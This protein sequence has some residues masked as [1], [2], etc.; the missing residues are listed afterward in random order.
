MRLQNR[1]KPVA[2]YK[3][4]IYIRHFMTFTIVNGCGVV[5]KLKKHFMSCEMGKGA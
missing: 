4:K 5:A 3:I 2:S 1:K